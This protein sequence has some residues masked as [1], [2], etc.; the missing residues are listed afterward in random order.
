MVTENGSA[1]QQRGPL[2][3]PAPPRESL[4]PAEPRRGRATARF[5]R[6]RSTCRGAWARVNIDLRSCHLT[7]M[8]TLDR[9]DHGACHSDTPSP[10]RPPRGHACRLARPPPSPR[11]RPRTRAGDGGPSLAPPVP[12]PGP[13]PR[14]PR[15]RSHCHFTPPLIH[16]HFIP[17]L[18]TD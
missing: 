13:C 18:L 9:S 16:F 1:K 2:V 11:P 12:L 15:V 5:G 8:Y 7:Y 10:Q 3:P 17:D 4:E 14:R 6:L